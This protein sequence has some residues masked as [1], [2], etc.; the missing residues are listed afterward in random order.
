M[1]KEIE[2]FINKNLQEMHSNI[3]ELRDSML[4]E[5]KEMEGN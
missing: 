1:E 3:N 4:K 5:A 2:C